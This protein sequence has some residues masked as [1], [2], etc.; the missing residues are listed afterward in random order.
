MD[1]VLKSWAVPKGVPEEKGIKHL[2]VETERSS[3][4]RSA[5]F[6]GEIPKGEYGGGQVKIRDRGEFVL[7]HRDRDKVVFEL[8]GSRLKGRYS[9]VRFS[10]RELDKELAHNED[11]NYQILIRKLRK[12]VNCK[13]IVVKKTLLGLLHY[14]HPA[15]GLV[16]RESPCRVSSKSSHE[17]I[18]GG[19]C[20]PCELEPVRSPLHGPA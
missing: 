14:L 19:R 4:W 12:R 7:E 11:M 16:Y 5:D 1:G 9:L 18:R 15:A 2:A 17:T 13:P 20:F 10:E 8:K 3:L 6:E